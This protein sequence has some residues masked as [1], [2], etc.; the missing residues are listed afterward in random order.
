[1]FVTAVATDTAFNSGEELTATATCSGATPR[2]IG[3]GLQ[4]NTNQR[5]QVAN[6]GPTSTTSWKATITSFGSVG[7]MTLTVS[8]ICVA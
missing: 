8:A 7:S 4:T 3:G 1:V 2:L 5:F 6:S